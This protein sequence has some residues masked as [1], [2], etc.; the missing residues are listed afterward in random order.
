[1]LG[2]LIA[3]LKGNSMGIQVLDVAGTVEVSVSLSGIMKGTP[4]NE[5]ATYVNRG[6]KPAE[7]FYGNGQ[8]TVTA[9]ESE[10]ATFTGESFGRVH[11]SG[12]LEWRAAIFYQTISTGKLA[13]L[14]NLVGVSENQVNPEGNA[15]D[16][17]WEWK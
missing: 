7:L 2:E 12:N 10:V 1:M 3:E 14:N 16:K 15:I 8:G 4:V 6:I 5:F 11:P 9:G 17:Q 13:F